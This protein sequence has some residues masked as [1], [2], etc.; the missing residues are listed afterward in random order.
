M[1]G[2]VLAVNASSVPEWTGPVM[3]WLEDHKYGG[4]EH[5]DSF[6]QAFVDGD[7]D[8]IDAL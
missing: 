1:V 6:R 8:A 5:A 7:E 4:I 2:G 3:K